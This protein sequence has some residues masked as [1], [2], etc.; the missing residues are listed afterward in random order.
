MV[1]DDVAFAIA[2]LL[3][4]EGTKGGLAEVQRIDKLG[5]SL[6]FA[7]PDFHKTYQG[8]T[9]KL[10]ERFDTFKLAYPSAPG[11]K[12]LDEPTTWAE[13]ALQLKQRLMISPKDYRIHFCL[14]G[15]QFDPTWMTAEDAKGFDIKGAEVTGK[16]ILSCLF[17][18][19]VEQ[20]PKAFAKGAEIADALIKN[21]KFFPT[22]QEKQGLDPKTVVSK[23]V[24]L[25]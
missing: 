15:T 11:I 4:N 17:P 21:K 7:D 19:L 5:F 2:E 10:I 14:P 9:A 23:A 8:V 18:A 1:C 25:V 6:L 13:E 20:N 16:P 3:A 22:W 24:V 12:G